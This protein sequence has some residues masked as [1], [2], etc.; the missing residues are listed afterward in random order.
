MHKTSDMKVLQENSTTDNRILERLTSN[1]G[2]DRINAHQES[3]KTPAGG[4]PFTVAGALVLNRAK[5]VGLC[6]A[7][8]CQERDEGGVME[9][10]FG[11]FRDLNSQAEPA[12]IPGLCQKENPCTTRPSL[13]SSC[14]FPPLKIRVVRWLVSP[15]GHA[16]DL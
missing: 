14:R 4:N 13:P 6:D 10:F 15:T 12:K 1:R 3:I 11:E 8:A 7:A 9:S 2:Q 5:I 16:R